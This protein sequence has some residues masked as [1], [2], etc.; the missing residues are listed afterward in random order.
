MT[1]EVGCFL[2]QGSFIEM[3]STNALPLGQHSQLEARPFCQE[4]ENNYTIAQHVLLRLQ[5]KDQGTANKC[6]QTNDAVTNY[7]ISLNILN[8]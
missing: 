8:I 1:G 4:Q 7:F 3:Q 2:M 5:P 6:E